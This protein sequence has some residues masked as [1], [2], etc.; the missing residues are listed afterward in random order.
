[1]TPSTHEFLSSEVDR[2]ANVSTIQHL[3]LVSIQ[4]LSIKAREALLKGNIN[5]ADTILQQ[6]WEKAM[7]V[8][9][10]QEVQP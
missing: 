5:V 3:A 10:P 8:V 9:E 4:G 1:M 6:I 7:L 2:L